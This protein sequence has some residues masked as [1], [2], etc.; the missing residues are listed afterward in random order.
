[1]AGSTIGFP[2][3]Y[4][5]ADLNLFTAP[6]LLTDLDGIGGQN[7]IAVLDH[8]QDKVFVL[9]NPGFSTPT[10]VLALDVASA[11]GTLMIPTSAT[12]FKDAN[13]GLND[14][15]LTGIVGPTNNSGSGK[16]IVGINDGT[17]NFQFRGFVT[18]SSPTGI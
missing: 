2:S 5:P 13:T 11:F 1:L 16:V 15:A 12:V 8:A 18:T 9:R 17:G 7:D 3:G 14:L 6:S 10:G 4:A